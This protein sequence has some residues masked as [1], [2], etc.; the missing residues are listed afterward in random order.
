MLPVTAEFDTAIA[1]NA[2][3]MKARVTINSHSSQCKEH[4]SQGNYQFHR[5]V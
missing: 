3:N 4:E 1:A 5:S 2:R